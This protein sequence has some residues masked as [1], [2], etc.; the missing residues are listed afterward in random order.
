[1]GMV[2]GAAGGGAVVALL[3]FGIYWYVK[4]SSQKNHLSMKSTP[5]N[6]GLGDVTA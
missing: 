3:G 1:M 5:T 6:T 2:I 4:R